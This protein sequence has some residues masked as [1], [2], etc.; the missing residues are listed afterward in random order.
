MLS[1]DL[2]VYSSKHFYLYLTADSLETDRNNGRKREAY[3]MQPFLILTFFFN[4]KKDPLSIF[5][6]L[7]IN[8]SVEWEA[9][10]Q[11]A[12]HQSVTR[13]HTYTDSHTHSYRQ[14]LEQCNLHVCGL[15][16]ETEA[17]CM[18]VQGETLNRKA[19]TGRQIQTRDPLTE[20]V[21]H[22]L[23]PI[24]QPCK[25]SHLYK[26]WDCIKDSSKSWFTFMTILEAVAT[27]F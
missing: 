5:Q 8:E 17:L 19:A 21:F 22:P 20:L 14:I 18:Q 15:W 13:L 10:A 26:A 6:V 12:W 25:K 23:N 24:Q 7:V 16:D 9:G 27:C 1:L 4:R 3:D 2:F 11:Q